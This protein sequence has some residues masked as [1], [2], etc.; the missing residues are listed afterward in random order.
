MLGKAWTASTLL[1]LIGGIMS[2]C[3]GGNDED[4]EDGVTAQTGDG[5]GVLDANETAVAPDGR[6]EISAF[7]ETNATEM[8]SGG[9]MHDHDNWGGETRKVIA[10]WESGLI[11]IPLFPDG[12]AAGTAIADYDIPEPYLVYEGTSQL[13]LVFNDVCVLETDT[14]DGCPAEHPYISIFVDYLTAAD[15]PGAFRQAG[16]ATPG[17]PLIIPVQPTETDMP[18]QTKSLWLFR[19]YTG[20]PNAWTYNL[21]ITA[22]KGNAVVE[23]PPHP[24]LYADKTERVIVD[25]E[26]TTKSQG[27]ADFYLYGTDASWVYPDRVISYGTER[28]DVEIEYLGV[29][30]TG[31]SALP[32]QPSYF[33]LDFKNASYLSKM[34]H[35]DSAG[36]RLKDEGSDGKTFTFSITAD[37]QSY[38]TPYGSKSRWGFRFMARMTDDTLCPNGDFE[39]QFLQ[40]CQVFPYELKYRMKVTAFGHST[41]EGV[42]DIQEQASGSGARR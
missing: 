5:N 10:Q 36:G 38:D 18:H 26:F 41:A 23:W 42:E 34:G 13:E 37:Q 15:E 22:V 35:G 20:E 16:K 11:P 1:L 2:G 28:V 25:G 19:I 7:K 6:G 27:T 24:N 31:G 4:G 14:G 30:G 32:V 39:Q 33:Y 21:T 17:Q 40:G 8:G 3:I 9:N 12:K 29:S